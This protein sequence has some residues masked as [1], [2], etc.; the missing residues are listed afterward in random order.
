[1]FPVI[2]I[3]A[4]VIHSTYACSSITQINVTH[5]S[6]PL[7]TR[8]YWMRVANRALAEHGSPCPFAAFATV[9][10]N[11]TANA[12][13]DEVCVGVNQMSTTGNPSA[14]GE[15]VAINNC[16]DILTAKDG[17]Y[18]LS[19]EEALNAFSQLSLYTNA[20][21]C[22]MCASAVRWAGFKEYIFGTSIGTLTKA[23]WDQIQITS[24]KIF[25]ESDHM[26]PRTFYLPDVL[27]NETNPYFMWQYNPTYPC[28]SGCRRTQSNGDCE[29]Y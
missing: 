18:R 13:G 20:E 19:P 14:H 27:T 17:R 5:D 12:R 2:L 15:M 1:M 23:G 8:F 29:P 4:I 3:V 21:S 10:V 28:P 11:H 7:S 24:H 9:I 16:T 26:Q 22:P 25:S 6:I